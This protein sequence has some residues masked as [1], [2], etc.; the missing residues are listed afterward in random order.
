MTNIRVSIGLVFTLCAWGLLSGCA[1]VTARKV[2]GEAGAPRHSVPAKIY[3]TDFTVPSENLRVDRSGE[4][5]AAFKVRLAHQLSSSLARQL[6]RNLAPTEII[7][8]SHRL[9]R[10]NAWLIVG[11]FDRVN[12]GSRALRALVGFGLGAT[13][14]VTTSEVY[15]LSGVRPVR[16]MTIQTT[17]GSNATPGTVVNLA[18]AV[19]LGPIGLGVGGLLVGT[20]FNALP[21]LGADEKRTAREITAVLSDYCY[22]KGLIFKEQA[23]VPKPPGRGQLRLSDPR[24]PSVQ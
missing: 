11:R 12:Q 3:V 7:P 6:D 9:S 23:M 10:G 20:G 24:R 2:V 13:K 16:L 19:A 1:S 18:P 21:G 5:L 4:K 22:R 17:G 15:D 14:V 8:A